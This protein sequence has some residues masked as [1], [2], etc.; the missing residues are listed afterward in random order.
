MIETIRCTQ[1]NAE[2]PKEHVKLPP[3]AVKIE[4]HDEQTQ[5]RAEVPKE[6]ANHPPAV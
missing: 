3:A 6:H 2:N 1:Q 4:S 5:H